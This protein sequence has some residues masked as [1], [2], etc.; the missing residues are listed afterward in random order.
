MAKVLSKKF[1][2]RPALKVAKDLVG[3]YL[4]QRS[5]EGIRRYKITEVEAYTGPHDLACHG[6]RGLTART[7]AL[8]GEPG[9]FYVYFVYGMYHMLNIVT[10]K[11]G[12]P[13]A[14]LIRGVEG[15]SGPGRVTKKLSID[16]RFNAKRARPVA[17]LW[18]EYN[19]SQI[20]KISRMPRIGVQY[21]GPVWSAKPYRFLLNSP[22]H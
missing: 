1:F 16:K 6:A 8:F 3:N 15:I 4:V 18:F 21:A 5:K 20:F 13:A 19:G 11:N 12:Y 9:H 22:A 14:V 17:G 7:K 2:A 10:E